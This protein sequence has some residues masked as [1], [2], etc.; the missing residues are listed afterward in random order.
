[1]KQKKLQK[2]K[3]QDELDYLPLD[4]EDFITIED[5]KKQFLKTNEILTDDQAQ[6]VKTF[7]EQ[8]MEFT[9]ILFQQHQKEK[10]QNNLLKI[11]DNE[12]E[13]HFIYPSEYRRA[14]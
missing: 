3:P 4:V 8:Y 2:I 10:L 6:L 1:M 12:K 7:L 14:S 11:T 13:S 5:I 9:F